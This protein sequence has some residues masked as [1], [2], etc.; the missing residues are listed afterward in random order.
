MRVLCRSSPGQTIPA[1]TVY[2]VLGNLQASGYLQ[3]QVLRQLTQGLQRSLT[4]PRFD[5]RQDDDSDPAVAVGSAQHLLDQAAA[6]AS[7]VSDLLSS[8]QAAISAQSAQDRAELNVGRRRRLPQLTATHT[9][10]DLAD[11]PE[12]DSS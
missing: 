6:L 4:D 11:D 7:D 12:G 8:A 1:P 2:E 5:V 3:V 10:Q 9:A